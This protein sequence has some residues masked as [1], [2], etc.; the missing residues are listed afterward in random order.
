MP[1]TAA[2]VGEH[3]GRA[4]LANGL[5]CFEFDLG[6]QG[7]L[8]SILDLMTDTELVRDPQAPRLLWRLGLRRQATGE[9]DW[10]TSA[11]AD[12]LEWHGRRGD[13]GTTLT[14]VS[15][16][17]PGSAIEVTVEVT[18][19]D[20]SALTAWRMAVRGVGE[21]VAVAQLAC[22]ILSGLVKLGEPA[23]G[24]ALLA[25]VQGEA[26]LYR[27]PF[28]V[29]D[30]LPLCAGAGPEM[31]DV[32]VGSVGGRYPGAIAVQMMALY[33][34][35]AGLY[36]AAYDA[37]QHPKDLR[38]GP[39]AD[40]GP[41]P[42]LSLTHLVG[43]R[44]GEAA[45]VPYDA[46]VGVFHGDWYDAAALYRAWAT[47]QWWCAEKLWDRDIASW[48]REGVGGVFQ[49]SNYHIPRL[50]LNH[51]LGTIADTVN[52]IS[53]DAGVPL[54]C[55]LFNWEGGGAWTGPK[56][57]FP[58][59]EGEAEFR[60]AMA[61]L[62]QAGNLGFVYITGNNWYVKIGYDPEWDSWPE[63]R[64][65][66]EALALRKPDG[67]YTVMS[68][69]DN[70]EVVRLC[71]EP[72]AAVE[73]HADILLTC[74]DLGCSVVQIDNFPCG[75]SEACYDTAHGHP[76]GHGPWWSEAC[77]R[78]LAEIRGRAKARHP[79]CALT[80]EGIAENFVPWL[81][82]YDQ[83][84]GNMEYFGHYARGMPM[85]GETV[86]LFS[87]IYNEYIGAYYAAMPECNRPEVLYWTRGLG[88]A[89]C[90]GVLPTAGRYFPDPPDHNPIALA[91]FKRVIRATGRDLYP[92]LMF[93]EML[94]P[95][96]ISVPTITAQYCK[97]LYDAANFRHH[98]DP[99]QRHE[100]TDRAVQHA[101]Y[102]GRDGSVCLLFVNVSD[103]AV[104]FPVQLPAYNF[105][106]PVDV[107]RITN[108]EPQ[109]SLIGV[110]L[111]HTVSLA[112][113]AFS[114]TL[115]IVREVAA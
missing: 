29:R 44:P 59:R 75:G 37:G 25:P 33:G 46:I 60:N 97:F 17:L 65:K 31:A 90:Q 34:D 100:V 21:D 73:L 40:L 107:Q 112:M 105:A 83:R 72:A 77:G 76:P 94:R 98:M 71:P 18:L 27:N 22:P 103:Q 54:L 51:S 88:K 36:F 84:A 101:A 61:R 93:G 81:D 55:L 114:I 63:F 50:D 95:P 99:Q 91:F 19:G 26:Y 110:S 5:V 45:Q 11:D 32:G 66:G 6:N 115:L 64:A 92:Y 20:G 111:P 89:I 43:E 113:E 41:A 69:Y 79:E 104:E 35:R 2:S 30:G 58:P 102:R 74:L 49:M 68:W 4:T 3:D 47:E 15:S 86:P 9:L 48:L 39:W 67:E 82:L 14:L 42:V 70:W 12:H 57:F 108:S 7:A 53:A 13:D 109:E 28:P 56:G 87:F 1:A 10:L 52:A 62:R 24:E 106:G 8:V 23:P 38:M 16:A 78:M 96:E 80:T 85:G